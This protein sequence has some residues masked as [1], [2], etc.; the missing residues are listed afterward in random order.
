MGVFMCGA[1]EQGVGIGVGWLFHILLLLADQEAAGLGCC[2]LQALDANGAA[3][4]QSRECR[5]FVPATLENMLPPFDAEIARTSKRNIPA[6]E[7]HGRLPRLQHNL[8]TGLDLD[9]IIDRHNR[10]SLVRQN[11]QLDPY[12][13]AATPAHSPPPPESRHHA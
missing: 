6:L 7:R 3:G 4:G 1:I 2:I 11:L 8:L 9:N 10:N 12:A 13:P 5:C